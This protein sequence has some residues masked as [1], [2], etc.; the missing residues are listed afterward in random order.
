MSTKATHDVIWKDKGEELASV[1]FF[2][3]FRCN[4]RCSYC[5]YHLKDN[6][7]ATCNGVNWDIGPEL[8]PE[9]WIAFFS[10]YAPLH[11]EICGGEP[12]I[13]GG[14]GQLIAQLPEDCTWAITSNGVKRFGG[15]PREKIR[16][17][18]GYTITVHLEYCKRP[19]F[20]ENVLNNARLL[21]NREYPVKL[22]TVVTPGLLPLVE[23]YVPR[24]REEFTVNVHPAALLNEITWED[25][26]EQWARVQEL[27]GE[28]LVEFPRSVAESPCYDICTAGDRRYWFQLPDG[29]ILRCL[30]QLFCEDPQYQHAT[31]ET[32]RHRPYDIPMHCHWPHVAICDERTTK[33]W[34][35]QPECQETT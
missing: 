1:L 5:Q 4:L 18:Y 32:K 3:T 34:G 30:S 29:K 13:Y 33:Q 19:G 16:K 25:L 9:A 10:E 6:V 28:G 27:A 12:T 8:S 35:A 21:R 17:C 2:P 26:P 14:L 22:T 15:L 11:V 24:W 7:L 31:S 23:Q 20:V